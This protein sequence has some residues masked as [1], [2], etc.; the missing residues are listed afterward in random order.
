M[1]HLKLAAVGMAVGESALKLKSAKSHFLRQEVEHPADK[2]LKM[3]HRQP[4]IRRPC[5]VVM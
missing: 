2:T 3:Y 5:D 4:L 1:H